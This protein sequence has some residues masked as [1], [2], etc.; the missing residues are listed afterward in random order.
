MRI[1]RER[2][3]QRFTEQGGVDLEQHFSGALGNLVG[4]IVR[5]V[6]CEVHQ[7]LPPWLDA[8]VL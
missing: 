6:G 1:A 7:P 8:L 5:A 3:D 4:M 2:R